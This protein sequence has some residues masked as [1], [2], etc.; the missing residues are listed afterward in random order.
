MSTRYQQVLA[1]EKKWKQRLAR[2]LPRYRFSNDVY[3]AAIKER[4]SN[5]VRWVDLG[6]GRND[7]VYE[8]ADSDPNA[9]GLDCLAHPKLNLKPTVRFIQGDVN[10]LPFKTN[11]LDV[12]SS[13]VLMEHLQEPL[14]ALKEM[15]RALK[16]GG[17]LIFRTPNVLHALNVLLKFIPEGIK[18]VLINKI[19]GVASADV[20]P[21]YYRAN[22]LNDLDKLCRQ[23]GFERFQIQPIEDI[24]TA[25]SFFF[26]LSL[27]YYAIVQFKPFAFLR[28]NFV[29]IAQKTSDE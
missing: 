1:K 22:R 17:T 18:K 24:H 29:V 20:F 19:F 28:T 16:P 26:L 7:L 2:W 27:L 12:L 8:L 21:T 23:A 15:H 25:F 9:F 13:N 10:R 5:R 3:E 14:V 4:L 11:S 6:C